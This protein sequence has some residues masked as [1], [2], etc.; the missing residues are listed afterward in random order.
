MEQEIMIKYLQIKLNGKVFGLLQ[1]N[2]INKMFRW[3]MKPFQLKVEIKLKV[4]H[5]KDQIKQR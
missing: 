3:L 2:Q 1:K 5:F 4:R